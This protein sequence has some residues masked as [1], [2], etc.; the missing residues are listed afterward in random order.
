MQN[1]IPTHKYSLYS[2]KLNIIL[3]FIHLNLG[4]KLGMSGAIP[5]LPLRAFM[6][7]AGTALPVS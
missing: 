4:P 2:N 3:P 7:W 6:V 5:L 1:S